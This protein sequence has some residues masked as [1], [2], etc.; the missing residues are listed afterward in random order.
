MKKEYKGLDAVKIPFNTSKQ[1]ILTSTK[2]F[3]VYTTHWD[4]NN[5]LVCD[6]QEYV[7][8]ATVADDISTQR[9]NDCP[10]N[11]DD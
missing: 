6:S 9:W 3:P 10:D 11:E 5:N 2:C 1:V 8:G 7:P 4:T